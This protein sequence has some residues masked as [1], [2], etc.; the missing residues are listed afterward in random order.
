MHPF[1]LNPTNNLIFLESSWRICFSPFFGSFWK[2]CF[3]C[4]CI[5]REVGKR[6]YTA[7][8]R[9]LAVREAFEETVLS[10]SLSLSL[11]AL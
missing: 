6:K 10:L 2:V 11:L 9:A 7:R 8:R 4:V 5:A 1:S 3:V